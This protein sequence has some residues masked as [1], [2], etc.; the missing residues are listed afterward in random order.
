MLWILDLKPS[1]K[2][3]S[4][5]NY[6]YFLVNWRGSVASPPSWPREGGKKVVLG[7]EHD[8]LER[9][10]PLNPQ[11]GGGIGGHFSFCSIRSF[12]SGCLCCESRKWAQFRLL[13]T[14]HCQPTGDQ[15]KVS[16]VQR[17]CKF[18]SIPHPFDHCESFVILLIKVYCLIKCQT[19]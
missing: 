5:L 12:L 13:Q 16:R 19:I 9:S 1:V 17:E 18:T 15:R 4:F 6:L 3:F 7:L 8:L 14:N 2:I 11:W 10:R